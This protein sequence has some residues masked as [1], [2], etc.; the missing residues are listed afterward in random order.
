MVFTCASGWNGCRRA[1]CTMQ[2]RLSITQ[3]HLHLAKHNPIRKHYTHSFSIENRMMQ[4]QRTP[5]STTPHTLHQSLLALL[6]A[7]IALT[8]LTGVGVAQAKGSTYNKTHAAKTSPKKKSV[9][10]VTYQ[11]SASEETAAERDRRMFREC[12]GLHNAGAC[13][14][15]TRK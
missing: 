5:H 3:P 9:S 12:R 7:S 2:N 15:Y 11:R 4:S 1:S 13:R 10:K 14:G 8:L 6:A